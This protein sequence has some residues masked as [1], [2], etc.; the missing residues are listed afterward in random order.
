MHDFGWAL[1][2]MR[3]GRAVFRSG[4]N[5]KGMWLGI[6]LPPQKE[7]EPPGYW[8]AWRAHGSFLNDD[9][10]D[11]PYIY[12]RTATMLIVPWLASQT[13]MLAEDWDAV[14]V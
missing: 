10:M 13:D 4:W 9:V 14:E 6:A 5:G 2:Q 11:L 8:D 7:N 3:E 12:M 1:A